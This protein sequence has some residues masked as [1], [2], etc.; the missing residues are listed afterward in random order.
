MKN[1]FVHLHVHTEYSLLDGSCRIND[2]VKKAKELKMPSLAI[3]DHGSMYGTIEFYKSALKT[4]AA[5]KV[6]E[7]IKYFGGY[8]FN[9]SHTVAYTMI[10]YQN[11]YI[12]ANYP[13]EYMAS[14]ENSKFH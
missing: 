8:A 2:L 10:S 4:A 13:L 11:A 12:K 6:W 14:L 3:T 5:K 7:L 1:N 9:K